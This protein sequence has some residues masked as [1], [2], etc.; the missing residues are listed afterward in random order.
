MRGLRA[1]RSAGP[2]RPA[3]GARGGAPRGLAGAGGPGP[4]AAPARHQ[5]PP[6][7]SGREALGRAL[8]FEARRG[9]QNARGSRHAAFADYLCAQ[10]RGFLAPGGVDGGGSVEARAP[11]LD[12]VAAAGLLRRAAEYS[13]MDE[14]SREGLLLEVAVLL[15]GGPGA[16]P[17]EVLAGSVGQSAAAARREAT[18]TSTSAGG[19]APP[20]V[21]AQP[22]EKVQG[23]FPHSEYNTVFFDFESTGLDTSRCRVIDVAAV[24]PGTG[25]SFSTLVNPHIGF[26]GA[27]ADAAQAGIVEVGDFI[28]D[29]TGITDADVQA[30]GV[31]GIAE[32]LAQLEAFV[33]AQAPGKGV[34][35]V[36]HNGKGY[37]VPLLVHEFRRVGREIPRSWRF[38]DTLSFSK[39]AFAGLGRPAP[40]AP[41][42]KGGY[43]SFSLE[44]LGENLGLPVNPEAHRALADSRHLVDVFDK[45]VGIAGSGRSDDLFR[46]G[47]FDASHVK[48]SSS[49]RASAG[50]GQQSPQKSSR[51]GQASQRQ[52]PW[53]STSAASRTARR[54]T[55]AP[56]VSFPEDEDLASH[57]LAPIHL[58]EIKDFTTPQQN[59]MAKA[60]FVSLQDLLRHYPRKH[61]LYTRVPCRELQPGDRVCVFG[62]VKFCEARI[63]TSK[64]TM[65][66]ITIGVE[67]NASPGQSGAPNTFTITEFRLGGRLQWI[68]KQMEERCREGTLVSCKGTVVDKDE[69]KK[70]RWN[71]GWE[72]RW[73]LKLDGGI[74]SLSATQLD[75]PLDDMMVPAYSDRDPLKSAAFAQLIPKALDAYAAR[76]MSGGAQPIDPIPDD[77]RAD[78]GLMGSLEAMRGF[79]TAEVEPEVVEQSRRRLVFEECFMVQIALLQRRSELQRRAEASRS[80][81]SSG[82]AGP[83]F[84]IARRARENLGFQFTAAQDRV[85][86]EIL[87]DM[88]GQKS[89]LRL[90]QGDVGCGKTALAILALLAVAGGARQ[91]A[92]MAPTD[93]LASQHFRTLE[94]AIDKLHKSGPGVAVPQVALLTGSTK[95]SDRAHILRGLSSGTVGIIVGT[96]ALIG[97]S[98][99]FDDLALAVVDEQHKFGV[100][101]RTRLQEKGRAGRAP[102]ILS[103]SATPIPRT[104]ALTLHGDMAL[105]IVDEKPPGRAPVT[106]RALLPAARADAY[107]TILAEVGKGHKAFVVCPAVMK[108]GELESAQAQFAQLS[109]NELRGVKCGLLHGQMAPAEKARVQ[110]AFMDGQMQVLIATVVVEVGVDIPEATVMLIE[111]ADRFGLAQLHQLRGRVGRSGRASYCFLIAGSGGGAPGEAAVQRLEVLERTSDGFEIAEADLMYRGPG[112]LVGSKQAGQ[113]P[114]FALTDLRLEEDRA[115]LEE[116]RGAAELV[117][118]S[119]SDLPQH[120]A[121]AL[122]IYPPLPRLDV[123][124]GSLAP[125]ER[126]TG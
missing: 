46:G 96:H 126:G 121:A 111:G 47:L 94:V 61:N 112:E 69:G 1:L 9:F 97:E 75:S 118:E 11:P 50:S 54:F 115:I 27:G 44:S 79:H 29:L 80:E 15:E 85:M 31:P 104:L 12:L 37:D 33:A 20:G 124:P 107:A 34:V 77:I 3:G 67:E 95:A 125:S 17:G 98:V 83:C 59:K 55:P 38:F 82:I 64:K 25:A 24:A 18:A 21:S 102:H 43:P 106:T 78:W 89:M 86:G 74:E 4:R 116:A 51:R 22:A 84:E 81:T 40:R 42:S 113:L 119:S 5:S 62:T 53:A 108:G 48:P 90:V 57:P 56:P 35:L 100:E 114:E 103:M 23:P 45:L 2:A 65:L 19:R 32:A 93:L 63:L 68:A 41:A 52:E 39:E 105:S 16:V 72:A 58:A 26:S 28:T 71:R 92:L 36:A 14:A 122:A 60:G 87:G 10:L 109:Q 70:N 8:E 110:E 49:A 91:G 30:E 123:L 120:L 66:I 88:K 76:L 7:P 6:G 99:V 13:Q 101:Q 73:D 117:M